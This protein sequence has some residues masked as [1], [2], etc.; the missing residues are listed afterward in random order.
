M[1]KLLLASIA[2]AALCGVPAIAADMPTKAPIKA[3]SVSPLD[4]TVAFSGTWNSGSSVNSSSG[5]YTGEIKDF[6]GFGAS[7]A[8]TVP[9]GKWGIYNVR[10]GPQI[11]WMQGKFHFSGLAGGVQETLPGRQT[12][13]NYLATLLFSAKLPSGKDYYF[14][15]VVGYAD[16]ST[17]GTPCFGCPQYRDPGAPVVGFYAG[18]EIFEFGNTE[19]WGGFNYR[20]T[21]STRNPT[22][23]T[24]IFSNRPNQ[25]VMATVAWT[26]DLRDLALA[27]YKSGLGK[28]LPPSGYYR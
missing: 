20:Y 16:V 27:A 2:I 6:G 10:F 28:N 3:E 9:V 12:Q 7:I 24:E 4:F 15:P 11:E 25:S 26:F 13:W 8:A 21:G 17:H 22:T 19:V 1:K 5:F 14:G 18:T 23:T